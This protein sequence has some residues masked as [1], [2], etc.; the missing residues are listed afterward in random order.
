MRRIVFVLAIFTAGGCS[1]VLGFKDPSLGE[2]G[3]GSGPALWV[4]TTD[5]SFR[6]DFGAAQGA[7]IAADIKCND[8][9]QANFGNRQ[10][11]RVRAVIQVEGFADSV[12][13]MAEN[14][15]IPLDMNVS[16]ALDA[17]MVSA[18]WNDFIDPN[19]QLIAPVSTSPSSLPVWSGVGTPGSEQCSEWTSSVSSAF[20]IAGDAATGN[21][22]MAQTEV[23]CSSFN[24]RLTCVCW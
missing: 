19:K 11:A 22:W 20:G 23:A 15:Q 16:R 2:D 8:T 9:Y 6:G 4:F 12:G 5:E 1:S 21:R 17:V 3:P 13:R 24:P 7:R 10:C 14:Y 18:T